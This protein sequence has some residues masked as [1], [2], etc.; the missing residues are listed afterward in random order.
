[1]G[2]CSE[3]AYEMPTMTP[4]MDCSRMTVW[5]H[6][7]GAGRVK[8]GE[9]RLHEFFTGSFHLLGIGDLELDA[10]L[11]DRSVGGPLIA[12]EARPR[13]LPQR[14]DAE[15][16]GSGDLLAVQVVVALGGSKR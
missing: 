9:A 14:P 3:G 13:G 2:W 11:R 16:L 10:G 8:E 15:V 4:S 6:R 1:M 12:V 7:L 5:P